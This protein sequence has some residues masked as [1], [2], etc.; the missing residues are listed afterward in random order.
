MPLLSKPDDIGSTWDGT[1]LKITA[2]DSRHLFSAIILAAGGSTRFGQPKQLLDWGGVP[3]LAHV[4]DVALAAGLAPVVVVLGCQAEAA[5]AALG[6][7]VKPVQ[8]VMNWRWEEGLSTSVQVGLAALPPGTEAAIFLQC[9][10]PLITPDL[11][12]ALVARFEET[13]APIVHPTHA[14]QRST[15]VLFASRL[16]PELAKVSGDEGGRRLITRY[17]K[18]VATVE[19]TDP[20]TLS[21]VDTPADYERLRA[22]SIQSPASSIQYPASSLQSVTHLIID[23][24]GVLW[25]GDEPMPGLQEFFA[26]LR[27]R[28]IGLSLI[29][30]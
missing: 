17:T 21:D 8:V 18:D 1:P 14:G 24:D 2:K 9:D 3:L 30:I 5:R 23:M 29:H 12:R 16:F 28:H 19:V 4:A 20:D 6:R 7:S 25:R 22:S 27:Q 10:Q 11:L 26:F 13:G 15:P